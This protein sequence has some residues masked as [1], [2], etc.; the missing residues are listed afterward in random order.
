MRILTVLMALGG[1]ALTLTGAWAER[2]LQADVERG[3]TQFLADYAAKINAGELRATLDLYADDPRFYWVEAGRR[4]YESK[5]ELSAAFDEFYPLVESIA[6]E[7]KNTRITALSATQAVVTTEFDQSITMVG[8]QSFSLSGVL[9]VV[10]EKG[11]AGWQFLIGHTTT[12][13]QSMQ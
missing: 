8:N 7:A 10:L 1:L 5:A 4:T 11:D 9:T 12:L 13:E 3:V 2:P 6:F